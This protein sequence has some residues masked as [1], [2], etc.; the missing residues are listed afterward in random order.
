[1]LHI[2][3]S[4]HALEELGQLWQDGDK[5]VFIDQAVY[6]ALTPTKLPQNV[7]MTACALLTADIQARGLSTKIGHEWSQI[8]Y[9]GFVEL[10]EE[11][12]KTLTWT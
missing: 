7:A 2:V 5:A 10:T 1:M 12:E 4:V 8:D 6:V 11:C 9:L 3:K